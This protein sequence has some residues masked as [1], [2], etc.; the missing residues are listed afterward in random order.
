MP[1][2]R[3]ARSVLPAILAACL[4]ACEVARTPRPAAVDA[5][6]VARVDIQTALDAYHAALLDGDAV[7]A[8]SFFTSHSRVYQPE[9]PDIVGAAAVRDAL[10][11]HF[12]SARVTAIALDRDR[13][14]IVRG[15]AAWESGTYTETVR[16]GGGP[17]QTRRGRYMVRWQRG[18]ESRWVID[19]FLNHYYP[20]DTA[21]TR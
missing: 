17:E 5:D 3:L 15:G 13:I 11:A 2:S 7:R 10:A 9:S 6:S 1:L 18:P 16:V 14:D 8:A 20:P 12:D 4:A 19:T 21:A